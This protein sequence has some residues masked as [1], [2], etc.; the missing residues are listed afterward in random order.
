MRWLPC[1]QRERALHS[2]LRAGEGRER[3]DAHKVEAAP[4]RA[5]FGVLINAGMSKGGGGGQHSGWRLR[6][7][8]DLPLH[9]YML[10]LTCRRGGPW[11]CW[12]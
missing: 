12:R 5:L 8:V 3:L 11:A 1:T 9:G 2:H 4:K 10:C 6:A 7:L